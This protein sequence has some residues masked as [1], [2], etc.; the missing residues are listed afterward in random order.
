MVLRLVTPRVQLVD[1]AFFIP[2]ALVGVPALTRREKKAGDEC[3]ACTGPECPLGGLLPAIGNF[4]KCA[5]EVACVAVAA[6]SYPKKSEYQIFG[7]N[8]N[9]YA[10]TIAKSCCSQPLP[11]GI[12]PVGN[13]MAPGWNTLPPK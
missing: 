8:S 10:H 9:T 5:V 3:K 11:A 6:A 1:L 13:G 4:F 12:P 7:P 2:A